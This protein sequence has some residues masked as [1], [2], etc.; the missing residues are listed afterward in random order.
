MNKLTK[1]IITIVTSIICVAGLVGPGAANALTADELQA[2]ITALLAQLTTLQS[3]LA[4]L[5]GT[6]PTGTTTC[7]ITSF[8]SNL[9]QGSTG[10]A[11]KCLQIVL[12]TAA[13]TQVATTGAGSPGNES[14]YFGSLTKAAVV[15]FQVKYAADILTPLGLTAGTGFVGSSTRAKLNTMLVGG[16]ITTPTTPVAGGLSA[17]LSAGTP[18]STSIISYGSTA[19]KQ[20][21]VLIPFVTVNF[22]A[23]TGDVKVTNIK[24]NRTG[25]ASDS[26]LAYTYLYDGS[27]KLTEGGS[28]SAKVLTFNDSTG[29][30]T[31]PAGTT[32]SIT[33]V[34]NL[35]ST[36]ASGQTLGFNLVAATDVTFKR[37]FSYGFIPG[38]RQFDEYC[39]SN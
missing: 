17:A 13:D 29:L 23:G 7:T 15:K 5:Q 39:R 8:T 31:V 2:Q 22:T 9:A 33:L 1:K 18:A 35:S 20:A 12:N 21:Q 6:T 27:T 24:F 30:F 3:Q 10:D 14:S 32:K 16:E 19:A 11:V 36:A 28:I 38:Y 25:I 26:S 37:H 34:G 4:T